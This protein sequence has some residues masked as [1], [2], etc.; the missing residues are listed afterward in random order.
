MEDRKVFVK[1]AR[2]RF[3]SGYNDDWIEYTGPCVVMYEENKPGSASTFTMEYGK[4]HGSPWSMG[5]IHV[6]TMRTVSWREYGSEAGRLIREGY[7]KFETINCRREASSCM[8]L[9]PAG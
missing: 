9:R 5:D 7:E 8:A 6:D 1:P 3:V 4:I 2:K